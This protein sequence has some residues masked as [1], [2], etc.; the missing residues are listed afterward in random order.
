MTE[1]DLRKSV[2]NIGLDIKKLQIE[3]SL[4]K[5]VN[6][7]FNGDDAAPKIDTIGNLVSYLQKTKN[8][9]CFRKF[10][11]SFYHSV[12]KNPYFNMTD[13]QMQII[14]DLL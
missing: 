7:K 13:V 5:L 1:S 3:K 2:N 4:F 6:L 14:A 8:I 11:N 9:V 12:I 10:Y